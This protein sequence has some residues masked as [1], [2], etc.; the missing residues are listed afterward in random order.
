MVTALAYLL[1]LSLPVWLVVEEL[2]CQ[3]TG[4]P[5]AASD[6]GPNV[7]ER[8]LIHPGTSLAFA[9]RAAYGAASLPTVSWSGESPDEG[10]FPV[11]PSS[12]SGGD[13]VPQKARWSTT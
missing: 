9:P 2:L 6:N 13:T 3:G 12:L 4:T 8:P 5:G 7:D 10:R 11:R 1:A